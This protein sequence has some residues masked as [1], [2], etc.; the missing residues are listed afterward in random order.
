[1]YFI[2]NQH[3]IELESEY[4]ATK[5]DYNESDRFIDENFVFI[6]LLNFYQFKVDEINISLLLPSCFQ[7]YQFKLKT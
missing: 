1:M 7:I 3:T 5:T 4:R 2:D 6:K